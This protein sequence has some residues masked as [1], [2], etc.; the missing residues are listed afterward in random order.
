MCLPMSFSL[1]AQHRAHC[2]PENVKNHFTCGRLPVDLLSAQK[3]LGQP[4]AFQICGAVNVW[5]NLPVKNVFWD[6]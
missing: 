4:H 5:Q 3:V 6:L 1:F 2:E